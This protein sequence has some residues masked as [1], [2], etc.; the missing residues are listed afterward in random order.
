M[1]KNEERLRHGHSV[2]IKPRN[3]E[4]RAPQTADEEQRRMEAISRSEYDHAGQ[5]DLARER[6][7]GQRNAERKMKTS[8]MQ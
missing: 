4:V 1:A 2:G 5:S 6:R 7:H 8:I 3:E